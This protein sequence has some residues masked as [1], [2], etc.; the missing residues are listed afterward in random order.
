[1]AAAHC[2]RVS[3]LLGS[4]TN[5]PCGPAITRY[6]INAAV[7][8]MGLSFSCAFGSRGRSDG[9]RRCA[10]R[11]V[12]PAVLARFPMDLRPI[13]R[14]DYLLATGTSFFLPADR[15]DLHRRRAS[16][17]SHSRLCSFD[18]LP[19]A[20]TS[21]SLPTRPCPRFW[22][23]ASTNSRGIARVYQLGIVSK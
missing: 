15:C 11:A 18:S 13:W 7:E 5:P 10:N 4:T 19:F 20:Q 22:P 3:K 1:M 23:Y 17:Q 6:Q 14:F 2:S 21:C 8:A 12:W 9:G 16:Q